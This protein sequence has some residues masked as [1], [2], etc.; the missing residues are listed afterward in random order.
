VL[1]E[2]QN[3][4]D[5]HLVVN[6]DLPWAIIRLVQRA[7][8]VDR[9]GQQ[10]GAI[11]CY[12]FLPADGVER[13]IHLRARVRT[14]LAQNAEVVGTDEAFFEDDAGAQA[15]Q[16]LY[17]EKAGILDG[18]ADTEVDLASYA[19]QIWKNAIDANPGLKA[20]IENLP[21]VVYAT[22]QYVGTPSEPEGVLLY[23]R[24]AQGNDALA[25]VDREG[26]PV[27]ES[28]LRI[29]QKAE[30]PP[31]TPGMPR[32]PAHHELVRAGVAQITENEQ[33]GGGQLGR[34][35]GARYR[36]YERLKAYLQ[37]LGPLFAQKGSQL[38][39]ALDE[40]YQHPLLPA[41]TDTLNRQ[42]RA[43]IDDAMLADLVLTLRNEDRLCRIHVDGEAQEPQILC[44]MGLFASQGDH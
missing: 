26:Q 44:S 24:T 18:E 30:C 8:R 31:N 19:Y 20:T 1:S 27:S 29:L 6:Y 36:T 16:D 10:A 23:I 17:S 12:S 14:R 38:S 33:T 28:Q 35:S 41:A 13:I 3:L 32:D 4:Q 37:G 11:R 9:I 21:P 15:W 5:A 43:G 40:I 34:P 2:G 25:W 42:L 7:G 39:R 22:R